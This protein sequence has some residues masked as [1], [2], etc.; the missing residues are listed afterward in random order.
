MAR[1]IVRQLIEELMAGE[2]AISRRPV[3][4]GI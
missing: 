1:Q 2:H 3:N 4:C